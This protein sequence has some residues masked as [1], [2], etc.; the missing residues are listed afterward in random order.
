[1]FSRGAPFAEVHTTYSFLNIISYAAI[2]LRSV[3][4]IFFQ[5][6]PNCLSPLNYDYGRTYALLF[7]MHFRFKLSAVV[8]IFGNAS[9]L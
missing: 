2:E 8:F 4:D 3:Y 5:H 1:M 9:S 7:Q 6:K